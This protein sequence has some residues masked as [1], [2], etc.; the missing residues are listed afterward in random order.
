[1]RSDKFAELGDQL[2]LSKTM[3][4]SRMISSAQL[5]ALRWHRSSEKD[6]GEDGEREKD[7]KIYQAAVLFIIL[8]K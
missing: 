8:L 6:D 1:M 3:H 7:G 5:R 2:R 4:R